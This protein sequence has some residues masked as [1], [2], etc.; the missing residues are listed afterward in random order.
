ML[1]R[2]NRPSARKSLL[3]AQLESE[4][5]GVFASQVLTAVSWYKGRDP[6]RMEQALKALIT[7]V[8]TGVMPIQNAMRL[9]AETISQTIGQ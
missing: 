5:V 8:G 3:A 9:A 1:A 2:A 6:E 7:N 4:R